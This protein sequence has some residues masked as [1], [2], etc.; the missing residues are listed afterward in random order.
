MRTRTV[1]RGE[2][3]NRL[4][5]IVIR[6]FVS[7]DFFSEIN[8]LIYSIQLDEFVGKN[9]YNHRSAATGLSF[10]VLVLSIV[11]NDSFRLSFSWIL[12]FDKK[13]FVGLLEEP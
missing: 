2:I 1:R 11:K 7:A 5:V 6:S 10:E 8:I 13:I 12:S 4:I 3:D 9:N